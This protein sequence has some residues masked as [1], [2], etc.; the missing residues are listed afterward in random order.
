MGVHVRINQTKLNRFH[1]FANCL[2]FELGS[3][4]VVSMIL[5]SSTPAQWYSSSMWLS[6]EENQKWRMTKRWSYHILRSMDRQAAITI[7]A[8]TF[9]VSDYIITFAI[10]AAKSEYNILRVILSGTWCI[11]PS[12]KRQVHMLRLSSIHFS[13]FSYNTYKY[14]KHHR[15]AMQKFNHQFM[16]LKG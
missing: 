8:R 14:T 9:T 7:T 4:D 16:A 13:F 15:I 12:A 3:L 1:T 10:N 6:S 11:M 5:G 2:S